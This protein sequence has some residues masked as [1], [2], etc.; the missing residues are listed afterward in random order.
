M[1]SGPPSPEPGVFAPVGSRRRARHRRGHCRLRSNLRD[2]LH[3][4][5]LANE[6]AHAREV[7][8]FDA[9]VAQQIVDQR[10]LNT[11]A[12]RRVDDFVGGV[13][14]AAAKARLAAVHAVELH[15]ADVVDL[16]QRFDRGRDDAFD[17]FRRLR[18]KSE[19]RASSVRMFSA[20][21][22]RRRASASTALRIRSAS[23][24]MRASSA[25]FCASRTSIDLRRLAS[26]VS[27]AVTTRSSASVAIARALSA[28]MRAASSS[29]GLLA[30]RDGLLEIGRLDFAFAVD[31]QT[32]AQ[33]FVFD[34]C[35]IET[36]FRSNTC[37]F[38]FLARCDLGFA[39]RLGD[40]DLE[41]LDGTPAFEASAFQFA[42]PRDIS[43]VDIALCGD[44]GLAHA[45]AG[46]GALGLG[47]GK[48]DDLF[49]LRLIDRRV[50]A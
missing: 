31:F 41:L 29:I 23:A 43:L 18:R 3:V 30:E 38:D 39:Q 26:S 1:R 35:L 19:N 8:A 40:G 27:R 16:L 25:A 32:A 7:A 28:S 6:T 14:I 22:S 46:A 13:A 24:E 33:R 20:S 4:A 17:V 49:F 45:G 44:F 10:R 48:L 5:R 21:L 42:L 34:A 36:T 50:D 9:D 11:I 2:A 12:Q 15:D 37:P 47:F